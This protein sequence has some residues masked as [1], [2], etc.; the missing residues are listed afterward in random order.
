M[1]LNDKTVVVTGGAN[2]IG[3]ALSKA[4]A[5]QGANV[6]VA[7]RLA[8]AATATAAE[9]GG[10]GVACDVSREDDIQQLVAA[11]EREY[12]PIDLFCSNAGI[13]VGEP[14]HSAS[15]SNEAWQACWD[16]HVMAHVYAARAVLPSMIARG[17]GYLV[18]MAS[19]AGLLSQI[20]D[21]AY[22][23]SKHAAVGF[24]ESLSIS[25]ADEGIKV[26]VICPQYVATS[27]LGYEEGESIDQCPGVISVEQVADA[28]VKGIDAEQ[29]LILPHPDVEQ[30]IQFKTANY[31]RWLGGMR[32]L[33]RNIIGEIGSTRVE[34]MH[35]LV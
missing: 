7:D 21:A 24:A 27:M 18:Q 9:I 25:H 20:G 3:R 16:V 2:G 22:S 10:L 28:V 30:Y 33:R 1:K 31:D 4:F 6:V 17:T 5:G 12:G 29:F 8:E 15:A 32:K 35:K 13:C 14:S 23:A 34:D 11:T 26:S 19:A